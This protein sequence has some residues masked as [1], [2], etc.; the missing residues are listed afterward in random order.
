MKSLYL[1]GIALLLSA[2]A[3]PTP[4]R[5]SPDIPAASS[6][7]TAADAATAPDPSP[8]NAGK[9]LASR[10]DV[11]AFM[12]EMAA[13]HRFSAAQLQAAFSRAYARPDIIAAMSRPAE[14]KPWYDYRTIFVNPK[15]IQGGVEFWRANAAAL[16]QAEQVYGVPPEIVVAII[17]VETQY[18]GNMGK[19]R[20]LEAL[21]TLAFDYPRRAAY[22]R[23]ELENYLLLARAEGIDP[24]APRGSYAGAM[25]LGQFMPSSFQSFAVDFD[26]DGRRDLWRNP[27]DAIGSVAH[28][29]QKNGWRSGQPVAVPASVSG[30]AWPA[31]V[32]RQINPP[33]SS[34]ARLRSQGIVPEAPVSDAQ[35]AMLL[36]LQGRDHSEYW[37]G[38]DNFYAITRYNRSLL[39]AMAV[40]QLSQEIRER[41]AR[42]SAGA[43]PEHSTRIAHMG[44]H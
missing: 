26:G 32:S 42:S 15:R 3:S 38:F 12:R 16:A 8:A 24:L 11:Q 18:G 9:P 41:Y 10:A 2:C 4:L 23:K 1:F 6:P 17:G 22:F 21:S 27:R 35:A 28:Y 33:Q 13:Q 44:I 37:L 43:L 7:P 30:A 5:P 19:Y 25:G 29:F 36:E 20:V 31:L 34:V 14:A 39:Y 40:Y